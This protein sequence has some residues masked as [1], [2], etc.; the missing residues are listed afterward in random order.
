MKAIQTSFHIWSFQSTSL[1]PHLDLFKQMADA[2]SD[3]IIGISTA[4]SNLNSS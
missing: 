1:R 4:E 3:L 2:A